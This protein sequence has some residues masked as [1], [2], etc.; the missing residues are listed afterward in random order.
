MDI[1]IYLVLAG[2]VAA[3]IICLLAIILLWFYQYLDKMKAGEEESRIRRLLT[4]LIELTDLEREDTIIELGKYIK[5]KSRR[6]QLLINLSIQ[7]VENCG[8][9]IHSL[10]L[11]LYEKSGVT[12]YLIQKLSVKNKY[13]VSMACRY[14]GDLRIKGSES[15]LRSLMGDTNDDV[16]YNILLSLAKLGDEEGITI[17]LTQHSNR[18]NL[19]Y[20]AIVEILSRYSGS[21]K[22]LIKK[23]I[24]SCDNYIKGIIIKAAAN[25]KFEDM[26][27]YYVKYIRSEDKNLRIACIRA[28]SELGDK[29]NESYLSDTLFDK[30][31]EVRA[32]A[33][34]GLEK[35]GTSKSF[36][37]LEKAASDN[38]WWVRHNAASTLVLIPGGRKYADKIL[39][40][41]DA[42]ARDAIK[43]AVEV[44]E[45]AA[46]ENDVKS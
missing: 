10:F 46:V 26:V 15:H 45:K 3:V 12:Q 13:I 23:I 21:K 5:K 18:L 41:P 8:P 11:E 16:I 30:A 33:A 43:Y 42:Y 24:D 20:R 6:M 14:L 36:S 34:K 2:S 1:N 4:D 37:A 35:I 32:A 17:I 38:E 31:W 7:Y 39:N 44:S 27:E 19:S 9:E 29:L 28:L 25:Y 40:G 22:D